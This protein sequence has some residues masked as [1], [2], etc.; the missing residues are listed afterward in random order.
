MATPRT[1]VRNEPVVV[2]FDDVEL[3]AVKFWSVEEP[4]TRRLPR[5]PR[6]VVVRV[7]PPSERA[8]VMVVAPRYALVAKRLVEEAVVAKKFV[9]VAFVV[10]EFPT[11]R[12]ERV[13]DENT[14]MPPP[15]FGVMSLPVEVAHLEFGVVCTAHAELLADTRP[16]AFAERQ[17][18][19]VAKNNWVV[20]AFWV[21]RVVEVPFVVVLFWPVKF[22]RV[23][24]PVARKL[25][26]VA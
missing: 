17:P 5:V 25:A 24:E 22:W 1:L 18:V 14:M 15:P 8:P 19:P 10:V 2:A 20:D 23:E 7:L 26:M 16:A 3:S 13:E 6:P 4:V 21:K 12:S 11:L 9:E